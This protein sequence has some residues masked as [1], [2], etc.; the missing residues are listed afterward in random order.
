MVAI[1]FVQLVVLL[2][3]VSPSSNAFA[4]DTGGSNNAAASDAS[5]S[6]GTPTRTFLPLTVNYPD[7]QGKLIDDGTYTMTSSTDSNLAVSTEATGS[8]YADVGLASYTNT[9]MQR[10]VFTYHQDGLYTVRSLASGKYMTAHVSDTSRVV[11]VVASDEDDEADQLWSVQSRGDGNYVM[12]SKSSDFLLNIAGSTIESGDNI[13]V[14]TENGSQNQL[15]KL[16]RAQDVE[17]GTYSISP[18][19]DSSLQIGVAGSSSADGAKLKLADSADENDR[20]FTITYLGDWY[21][22]VTNVASGKALGAVTSDKTLGAD[23]T[24]GQ[25]LG[26]A[27]QKWLIKGNGDGSYM[28]LSASSNRCLEVPGSS[29]ISGADLIAYA[30]TSKE[31]QRFMLSVTTP[32]VVPAATQ[33]TQETTSTASTDNQPQQGEDTY[34]YK[35][36]GYSLDAAIRAQMIVSS[37]YQGYS[38]SD[39]ETY[40]DPTGI[41]E[42]SG[43]GPMNDT[44]K[45]QFL[46]IDGGYSG[47]TAEEL[48][49]FIDSTSAGRSGTLH[50]TGRYFV[51]AA[52]QYNIN[53]VYL[54][55]H[56]ILESGWGTSSL[57][58]GIDSDGERYYNFFGIG[59]VDS[60]AYSGGSAIAVKYDWNSPGQAILGAG[61]WISTNYTYDSYEQNTVYKMRFNP[62]LSGTSKQYAT[63]ISFA[64]SIGQLM[65]RCYAYCESNPARVFE[66]PVYS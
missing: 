49:A 19:A 50:G 31:N 22:S 57:A 37:G 13:D 59:A 38:Y 15:F 34:L 35:E 9:G 2:C 54:L 61:W 3:L 23:V 43:S 65:G 29:Y 62:D 16:E 33:Q 6:Y 55:S 21:Y 26:L 32:K 8:E 20:K 56:A 25:Y 47:M 52:K 44:S 48:D 12:R 7:K 46:R 5:S 41:M 39:F 11:D 42:P 63:G 17:N 51:E 4:D 45:F 66:I 10:F 53:E 40:M 58:S 24:Q 64:N 36:Y 30:P 60:A 14:W 18:V 27:S 28:I 1:C